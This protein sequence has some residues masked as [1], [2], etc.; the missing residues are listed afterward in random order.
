MPKLN[1]YLLVLLVAITGC[2][3]SCSGDGDDE[4]TLDC[5]R[6]IGEI[7]TATVDGLGSACSFVDLKNYQRVVGT[8]NNEEFERISIEFTTPAQSYVVTF[9]NFE[10]V[11]EQGSIKCENSSTPA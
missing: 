8:A 1:Q 3:V 2:F 4:V 11:E 6:S 10:S 9:A 7:A 5:D